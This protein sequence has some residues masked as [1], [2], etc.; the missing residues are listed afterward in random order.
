MSGLCVNPAC[1]LLPIARDPRAVVKAY[2]VSGWPTERRKLALV[3]Q[4]GVPRARRGR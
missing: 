1:G 2:H 4:S 3:V